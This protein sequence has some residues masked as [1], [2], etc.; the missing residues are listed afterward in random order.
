M[1]A[2]HDTHVHNNTKMDASALTLDNIYIINRFPA[3]AGGV[4]R[5]RGEGGGAERERE[6]K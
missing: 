3:R 1:A 2:C 6:R 4:K 5:E